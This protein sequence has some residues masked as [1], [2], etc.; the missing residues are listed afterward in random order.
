MSTMSVEYFSEDCLK[1]LD[2]L[3]NDGLVLTRGGVPYA[4]V[5]LVEPVVR[6]PG[7][8]R[9]LKGILKGKLKVIG[10]IEGPVHPWDPDK[11]VNL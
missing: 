4:K 5:A 9:H 8:L 11:C 7:S 2:G 1:D 6:K 3:D 10:D